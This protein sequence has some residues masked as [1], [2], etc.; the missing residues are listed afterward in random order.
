MKNIKFV[1]VL[2]LAFLTACAESATNTSVYSTA[3]AG[4]HSKPDFVSTDQ[5]VA[6]MSERAGSGS[7]SGGDGIEKLVVQQV[8][9]TQA[10]QTQTAPIVVER[11]I[12]R[13]ADLQLEADAPEEA[14]TKITQI[15]ESKSG[16]VVESMQSSSDAKT[17]KR[18]TVTMT[19]RV[20]SAKFDEA[21]NE[22]AARRAE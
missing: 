1:P 2:F 9:L 14:Q 8:S 10:E 22:I 17:T 11:K 19:V 21:L 6:P 16:F 20:P 5:N 4:Y 7:G 12:I 15:A 3:N 18:D 13:N